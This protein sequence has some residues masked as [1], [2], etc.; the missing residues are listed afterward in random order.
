MSDKKI[1][2]LLRTTFYYHANINGHIIQV[3]DQLKLRQY[4]RKVSAPLP[5]PLQILQAALN[6]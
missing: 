2:H 5:P 6:N 3:H 1:S 4:L